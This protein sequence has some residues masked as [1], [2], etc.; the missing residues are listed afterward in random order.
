MINIPLNGAVIPGQQ[1][2]G[3]RETNMMVSKVF[4]IIV[5]ICVPWMLFVKPFIE[6][7]RA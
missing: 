3:T 7:S 1:F 5:F 2:F 6:K 4:F